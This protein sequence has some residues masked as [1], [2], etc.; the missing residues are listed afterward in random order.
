MFSYPD[1]DV[2]GFSMSHWENDKQVVVTWSN[3]DVHV[4]AY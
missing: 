2:K 4:M 3:G 1:A